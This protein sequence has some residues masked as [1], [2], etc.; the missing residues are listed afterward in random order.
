MMIDELTQAYNDFQEALRAGDGDAIAA[1][2][3]RLGELVARQNAPADLPEVDDE[4]PIEEQRA[5]VERALYDAA[6]SGNVAAA[7]KWFEL[8]PKDFDPKPTAEETAQTS[9]KRGRKTKANRA[10][11]ATEKPLTVREERFV[12]FYFGDSN[13]DGTDAAKK[14][15]YAGNNN[16]LAVNASRLLRKPKIQRLVQARLDQAT[17]PLEHVLKILGEQARGT[18]EFFLQCDPG[19]T[20]EFSLKKA[21]DLGKLHLIKGISFHDNNT[22]RS[23]QWYSSAEA[24]KSLAN[25]HRQMR[26]PKPKPDAGDTPEEAARAYEIQRDQARRAVDQ[27]MVKFN[28][29]E[30]EA[31]K[32][33]VKFFPAARE[34]LGPETE[35]TEAVN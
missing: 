32:R 16:V 13:G 19:C 7:L 15:G 24:A 3:A 2:N 30:P 29:T 22:V 27:I 26:A 1:A 8:H 14:A 25:I 17:I 10:K 5:E 18:A 4:I 35:P 28:L 31:A 6:T 33:A 34:W 23:I 9:K 21:A 20:P 12:E 11:K